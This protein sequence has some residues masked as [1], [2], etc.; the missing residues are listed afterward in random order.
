MKGMAGILIG[1]LFIFPGP[2]FGQHDDGE[3]MIQHAWIREAPPGM[4]SLA[5]YMTARNKS[6]NDLSLIEVHSEFFG[7]VMIHKTIDEG[8]MARMHHQD[9]VLV[10]AGQFVRFEPNGYHL[11]LMHPSTPLKSGDNVPVTLVFSNGYKTSIAFE[12][13]TD[14][15]EK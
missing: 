5:G 9:K 8:G 10:P 12:V 15:P 3:I 13:R 1:C 6:E 11:M 4:M 7:H 14:M 2:G